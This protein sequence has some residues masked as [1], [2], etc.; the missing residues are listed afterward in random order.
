[1]IIRLAMAIKFQTGFC[2]PDLIER[3]RIELKTENESEPS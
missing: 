3:R 2:A 1:M